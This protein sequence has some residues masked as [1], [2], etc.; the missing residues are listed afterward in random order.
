MTPPRAR[1]AATTRRRAR[2]ERVLSIGVPTLHRPDALRVCLGA[3]AE[4]VVQLRKE[5]LV[6]LV[7]ADGGA[8]E[9]EHVVEAYRDSFDTVHYL[10]APL[11]TSPARNC[12]A[13]AA[14]GELLVFVDDDVHVL[15]GSLVALV[16]AAQPDRVV[17]G[18]VAHLG[19]F[20]DHSSLGRIGRDGFGQ[21]VPP[22]VEPDYVI[23]AFICVP[24]EIYATVPWIDRFTGVC[25]DVVWGVHVRNA[26][27]DL[28][29]S[30]EARADHGPRKGLPSPSH[31]GFQAYVAL[32]RWR[33][34]SRLRAVRAWFLCLAKVMWSYRPSPWRM[35]R[36]AWSCV[37]AMTW[38]VRDRAGAR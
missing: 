33:R 28:A 11:G 4:E 15:P 7:V 35:L 17:A 31:S 16:A 10:S 24:R 6:E 32:E 26:G 20:G 5:W 19:H 1:A 22:G 23:S 27:F 36:A 38:F 29:V 3:I 13:R 21:P 14:T 25:D 37:R 8:P 12:L 34:V 18:R 2:P 30:E 9:S